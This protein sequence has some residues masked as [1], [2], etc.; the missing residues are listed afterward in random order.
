M[1]TFLGGTA[2]LWIKVGRAGGG[3]C[4]RGIRRS[5]ARPLS[6]PLT[7]SAAA[8][9]CLLRRE[10]IKTLICLHTR[11][12]SPWPR[13]SGLVGE[14]LVKEALGRSCLFV[15]RRRKTRKTT[16]E[17]WFIATIFTLDFS[18]G[19]VGE[20]NRRCFQSVV[21]GGQMGKLLRGKLALGRAKA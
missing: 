12:L 21:G 8:A 18:N 1:V 9:S 17:Q 14:G 6:H 7:S 5:S 19:L 4:S 3:P 11:K 16:A 10:P 15:G 20:G 13:V 2:G